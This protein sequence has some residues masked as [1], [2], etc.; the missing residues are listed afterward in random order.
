MRS[1]SATYTGLF[2]LMGFHHHGLIACEG[3]QMIRVVEHSEIGP[4]E[5]GGE[6][7]RLLLIGCAKGVASLKAALSS[8]RDIENMAKK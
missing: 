2:A 7:L 4:L 1:A 6:Q 3:F 8:F 5:F